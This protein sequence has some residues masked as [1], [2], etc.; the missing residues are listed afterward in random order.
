M[1]GVG[2]AIAARTRN[3]KHKILIL[4]STVDRETGPSSSPFTATDFVAAI[5]RAGQES[6]G[7]FG[8]PDPGVY[9][10]YVTNIIYLEGPETPAVNKVELSQLGIETLKCYGR[11]V[12]E[13]SKVLRYNEKA[14]EQALEAIIGRKDYKMDRSRRNT[15]E[16]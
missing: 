11:K 8:V 14:L 7:I 1:R 4:N 5:A 13:G 15:M 3:A 16:G 6:R 10:S 12:G 2:E 9:R